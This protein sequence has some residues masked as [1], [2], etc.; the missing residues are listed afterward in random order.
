M[1][2]ALNN[3]QK[4]RNAATHL[5]NVAIR[6]PEPCFETCTHP[7]TEPAI[8]LLGKELEVLNVLTY[9]ALLLD[10]RGF[11]LKPVPQ[12]KKCTCQGKP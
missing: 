6:S 7:I 8:G 10:Q 3:Y 1:S 12:E 4:A 5:Y 11:D 9:L 2:S